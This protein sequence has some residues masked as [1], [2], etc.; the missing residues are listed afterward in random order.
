MKSYSLQYGLLLLLIVV[1]ISV[2]SQNVNLIK[3]I[4]DVKLAILNSAIEKLDVSDTTSSETIQIPNTF[5][6]NGDGRNDLF[7]KGYSLKVFNSIG[8]LL[9]SGIDGWDGNYKGRPV[10]VDTYFYSV[11]V[12]D[13]DGY[14]SKTGFITLIR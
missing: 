4:S 1:A 11:L 14:V 3:V 12:S 5:S 2:N 13:V 8:I 7:L 6:P 10:A 9:Y